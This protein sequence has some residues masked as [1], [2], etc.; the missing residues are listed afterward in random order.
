ME[1]I[2]NLIDGR[3]TLGAEVDES[4][5]ALR[6]YLR[7]E[8]EDLLEDRSFVDQ[9]PMHFRTDS[10]EQARVPTVIERMRR[11]AGL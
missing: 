2:V 1:D 4:P 8:F 7:E 3:P 11:L 6:E 9:L 10:A 5:D